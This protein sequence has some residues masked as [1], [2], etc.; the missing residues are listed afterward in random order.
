[1]GNPRKRYAESTP[2]WR[3]SLRKPVMA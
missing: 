2:S 1:M 3:T